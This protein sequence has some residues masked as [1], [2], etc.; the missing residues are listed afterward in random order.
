MLRRLVDLSRY[1]LPYDLTDYQERLAIQKRHDR[2][3]PK[4]R[5]DVYERFSW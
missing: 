1:V 3:V 4:H 2:L 5:S